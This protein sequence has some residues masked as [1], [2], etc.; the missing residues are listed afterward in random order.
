M[1]SKKRKRNIIIISCIIFILIGVTTL[2]VLGL[3]VDPLTGKYEWFKDF[4]RDGFSSAGCCA[5]IGGELVL[6]GSADG[7]MYC[8]DS[9]TGAKKWSFQTGGPVFSSPIIH[10][11]KFDPNEPRQ[12][13]VYFGSLDNKIYS[14]LADGG[15]LIWDFETGGRIYSSPC[16]P[17]HGD[18]VFIGSTDEYVYAIDTMTGKENWKFKTDGAVYSTPTNFFFEQSNE[19]GSY[20]ENYVYVGSNDGYMYCIDGNSGKLGWKYDT[21]SPIVSSPA[22]YD[23]KLFFG[24]LEGDFYVLSRVTGEK[25]K[26]LKLGSQIRSSPSINARHVY[27]TTKNGRIFNLDCDN[28]DVLWHSKIGPGSRQFQSSPALWGGNL[29]IGDMDGNLY[30]F[31]EKPPNVEFINDT[32]EFGR[33]SPYSL[34]SEKLW[35]KNNSE[36]PITITFDDVYDWFDIGMMK[37]TIEPG[38]EVSNTFSTVSSKLGTPGTYYG[39]SLASWIDEDGEVASQRIPVLIVIED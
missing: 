7:N 25:I 36:N 33:C 14:L 18:Q 13:R 2:E 23:G 17:A 39:G 15:G 10:E 11:K 28:L 34:K 9:E 37:M 30:C 20:Y 8:Y 29:Y 31:T 12:R 1:R 27:I 4:D 24:N 38:E 26:M 16:I 22:L 32:I 6:F 19:E 5:G 3:Q 21:G 35:I